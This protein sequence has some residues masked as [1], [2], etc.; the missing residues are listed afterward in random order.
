MNP[1][2]TAVQSI[3]DNPNIIISQYY[4]IGGSGCLTCRH[5]QTILKKNTEVKEKIE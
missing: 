1:H 2:F 4:I 5:S 3:S